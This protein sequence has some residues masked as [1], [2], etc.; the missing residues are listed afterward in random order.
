MSIRKCIIRVSCFHETLKKPSHNKEFKVQSE[1]KKIGVLL[2]DHGS[3]EWS[4]LM[5]DVGDYVKEHSA[6]TD[7]SFGWCVHIA[8]YSPDSTTIAVK[9]VLQDRKSAVVISV[10]VAFD[11]MFQ[12]R[13]IKDGIEK[14][15]H[16]KDKVLYKPDAILPDKNAAD[17]VIF[18]SQ[19]FAKKY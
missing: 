6:M 5:T 2:I 14:V 10:L 4:N 17:W 16:S 15:V 3:R 8:H 19:D 13:I 11:E 1:N 7:Y 12:G 9:K 18:T